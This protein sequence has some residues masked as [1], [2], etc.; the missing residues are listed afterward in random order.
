VSKFFAKLIVLTALTTLV[1]ACGAAATPVRSTATVVPAPIMP[2]TAAP[3]AQA[4]L[5]SLEKSAQEFE[6]SGT[7]QAG[8]G[9]L[10]GDGD[11]DA[12]LA[13][14][15]M[16]YSQVWLND[17]SGHFT[18]TGQRLTQYGHG[19]GVADFDR[20][21]DLDAFIACHQFVTPSKVYLNDGSAS[22]QDTGQDLG[23][24][25]ISGA[26]LNLV[27]L[28]GDGNV[29][30]HVMYYDPNGLPDKV[31]LSDGAGV[32]SDSG[33]A[34][35]EETIAWGD[36]DGDGDIDYF[37][38]RWGQGY[39]VQLN[40]GGVQGGT[41]GQFTAG[42]HKDDRQSTNG[43][44]A[45][46]DFDGDGDLDALVANGFRSEGSYPTLLLLNDGT[47]QFTDSGQRLNETLAAGLGV[48]DL[49]A[50][51]DPDVF[52][53]NFDLPNEVWLNDGQGHFLDSGLRL[54]T[55]TDSS[56]R[57]S[58]DD[59]DGDGDLDVFVG[60]LMGKPEI[61]LNT[62]PTYRAPEQTDDGWQMVSLDE[63]GID[64]AEIDQAVALVQDN[65]YQNVHAILIVKDG[66]LA[67]ETYFSGYTWDYNGDQ[68]RGE[69]VDFDRDTLHNLA[70]VTKSFTSAL[71]GIAIDKG[72]IQSV[73]EK[74]CDFFPGY[75]NLC[76][77]GKKRI[78]LEHL[79]TMT[80]GLQ[81]NEMEVPLSDTH[82]DLIQLFL[83]PDPIGYILAKPIVSEPGTD[84]YY[85][86]G[87]TN[88][89]GEVIR[90]ATG[91][92][93]DDFAAQ[94][95]FAP[96]GITD[97]EWDHINP[98]VIHASGN[99]EL[100]P[101]DM[102]KLGDLYLNGGV[103]NG[104]RVLSEEW[105]EASTK[106]YASTPWEDGYGYQWWRKTYRSENV[107]VDAFYANGWGGQRITVFPSLD[108]VVVFTGG[109]YVGQEPV[110]EIITRYILPAV[111][112]GKSQ[113]GLDVP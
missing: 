45:L 39:V 69:Y 49:D 23:D 62:T 108:M 3:P 50:D 22:F 88:L 58:L 38:K 67:F 97:Y 9:D 28:N 72:F 71:I 55:D 29:D 33:L 27:D 6:V 26:E 7:F 34:L 94:Y 73:D 44:V 5:F 81:W 80:S 75:A 40:D 79:L 82:N 13:T 89:L 95:L 100:R 70:S 48:G 47:G 60:S 64:Q 15:L 1:S 53:S 35:D 31:Y 59:L 21:G 66:K 54:G 43:G 110:D 102:A 106:E 11:L 98:D 25:S 78:T 103:W 19:V 112:S 91:L 101:R 109:N 96:L 77:E 104:E 111:H 37:G 99:L 86:G 20:D 57:P 16:N 10:D 51:G 32:F 87:N 74:V 68:Y 85:S 113:P 17:G 12:V 92:R 105:I 36:L 41:L 90:E 52:V 83:V 63:V 84:W 8:L 4:V 30:V 2:P 18:N 76:D 14:P 65:T 93:M 42:W 61:W 24:T 56:T 107:S 46:A